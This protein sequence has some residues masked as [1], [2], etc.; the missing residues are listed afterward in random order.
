MVGCLGDVFTSPA[1]G[2]PWLCWQEGGRSGRRPPC[3]GCSTG[4]LLRTSPLWSKRYP[5]VAN[6]EPKLFEGHVE[7]KLNLI[8][9]NLIK[10]EE[11][12]VTEASPTL[13]FCRTASCLLCCSSISLCCSV[14]AGTA[15]CFGCGA[16]FWT[17]WCPRAWKAVT[18]K[19]FHC[20]E[21]NDN[22]TEVK[23]FIITLSPLW[24]SWLRSGPLC[25]QG[26]ASEPSRSL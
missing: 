1:S 9:F 15:S 11:N 25:F 8:Q 20:V 24:F 19:S 22:Q 5:V 14:S 4:R 13:S 12:A 16:S 21:V 26:Q 3:L 2:R 17:V 23:R 7:P 10:H 6:L 18:E